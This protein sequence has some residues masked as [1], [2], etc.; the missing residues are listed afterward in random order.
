LFKKDARGQLKYKV[1]HERFS[2]HPESKLPRVDFTPTTDFSTPRSTTTF[3]KDGAR[4]LALSTTLPGKSIETVKQSGSHFSWWR[5]MN[6]LVGIG[7]G[8]KK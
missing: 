6:F 5:G 4:V 2:R 8:G 3:S 1:I 7:F